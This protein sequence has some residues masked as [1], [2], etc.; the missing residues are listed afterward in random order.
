M[1]LTVTSTKIDA[2]SDSAE[3]IFAALKAHFDMSSQFDS[4]LP[5][6]TTDH[7]IYVEPAGDETWRFALSTIGAASG[8]F[9]ASME[10]DKATAPDGLDPSTGATAAWSLARSRIA[11]HRSRFM[12]VTEITGLGRD[13]VFIH[14]YTDSSGT[15]AYPF[16]NTLHF[17]RIGSP[18]ITDVPGLDGLGFLSGQGCW[19][20]GDASITATDAAIIMRNTGAGQQSNRT[21]VRIGPASWRSIFW[22][23][24]G[25]RATTGDNLLQARRVLEPVDFGGNDATTATAATHNACPMTL[26]MNH[27]L[28]WHANLVAGAKIEDTVNGRAFLAPADSATT[29]PALASSFNQVLCRCAEALDP[30]P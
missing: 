10:P 28:L 1:S 22:W 26:V 17:G 30:A 11:G 2:A 29:T 9:A 23:I 24:P 21:C 27:M 4:I 6:P 3:D 15:R 25:V 14:F 12:L 19:R 7:T 13:A 16:R 18:K 8:F 5:T 20:T